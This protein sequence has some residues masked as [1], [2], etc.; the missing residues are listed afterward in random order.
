MNGKARIGWGRKRKK[1]YSGT[2]A[3]AQKKRTCDPPPP[4]GMQE[5]ERS[6]KKGYSVRLAFREGLATKKSR[7]IRMDVRAIKGRKKAMRKNMT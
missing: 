7:S 2:A 3:I 4:Q 1:P 5:K 6:G